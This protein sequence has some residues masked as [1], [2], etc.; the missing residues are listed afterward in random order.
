MQLFELQ[1]EL[2]ALF[3][4]IPFLLDM[5]NRQTVD[6]DIWQNFLSKTK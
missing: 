5:K 2:A 1:A 6:L 3:N 4:D